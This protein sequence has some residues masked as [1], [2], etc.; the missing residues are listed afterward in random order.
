MRYK[1]LNLTAY[2]HQ[3]D[4]N[5]RLYEGIRN[6]DYN[7]INDLVHVVRKIADEGIGINGKQAG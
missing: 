6:V 1:D 5:P 4:V 7:N 2:E 3:W